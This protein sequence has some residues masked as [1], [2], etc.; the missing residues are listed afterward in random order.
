MSLYAEYLHEKTDVKILES[1]NAFATYVFTDKG[2]WIKDIYVKPEFRKTNLARDL[3]N[4]ISE[5]AKEKGVK[6]L[7]GSVIPSNKNSTDSLKVL[8]AYGMTLDS[9]GNDFILFKREL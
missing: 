7:L 5:I 1:P 4:M 6:T 3:A 8:L 2:C 9:C